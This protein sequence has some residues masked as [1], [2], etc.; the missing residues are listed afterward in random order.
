MRVERRTLILL[1]VLG[2]LIAVAIRVYSGGAAVPAPGTAAAT[3]AARTGRNAARGGGAAAAA[4]PLD[5]HL[6][7]LS[8]ERAQPSDGGRNPFQFR[9]KPAPAASGGTAAAGGFGDLAPPPVP[10]GPPPPPPIALKYIGLVEGKSG[11]RV[12]VLSDGRSAPMYGRQGEIVDGRYRIVAI[13]VE[14]IELEHVDGRGRQTI[15]LTG[16]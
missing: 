13:G 14:S 7:R 10:A 1:G 9:A 8:A 12:A 15:R 3:P 4:A 5:V 6:D 16:Q 2:V 11:L